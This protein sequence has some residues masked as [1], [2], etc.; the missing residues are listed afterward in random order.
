MLRGDLHAFVR[1]SFGTVSPGDVFLP[2]WHLEAI[3]HELAK[4]VRGETK[5][6]IIT[7]PPRYLKSIC[8]S[9]ALRLGCLVMTQPQDCMRELCK[10]ACGQ[11]CPGLSRG[12]GGAMVSASFPATQIDPSKNT[13]TEIMTTKRGFRLSTSVGGTLTGRGGNLIIIDD[14]L[15]PTDAQSEKAR[16]RHIEWC[17]NTLFSRL[18]NKENDAI[19]LIM[20][21]LHV[22]DLAGH[23]LE[24]GGWR[25]LNLPAIA[26]I[27]EQV[28]IGP[29]RLHD[30]ARG[31]LLHGERESQTV[32]DTMKVSMGSATFAA[33]YQ[34][35]PVP[36]G[37]NMIDWNWF[38]WHEGC[39]PAPFE[40][41]V[42]SWDTAMK[43]TQLADYSVATVWGDWGDLFF[44]LDLVRE[45][46]DYPALR[47]K[48]I[49]LYE[50][51]SIASGV[52][53]TI[54]I[55]DAGSGTSLK[56]DLGSVGIPA[57][58]VKPRGDKV[59]RMSAVSAK[60]EA[61]AVWLPRRAPWLDDLRT[62]ILAFPTGFMMIRWI[63]SRKRCPGC[64]NPSR[65]GAW[66]EPSLTQAETVSI[67]FSQ[68]G[69]LGHV[70]LEC[71]FFRRTPAPP[72]FSSISTIPAAS[73]ANRM[74][75]S[76]GAFIEVSSSL[77]SA[78]RMVA[79][80][81]LEARARS[82][83]LQR[84]NARAARICPPVRGRS[85]ILRPPLI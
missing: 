51:W 32:L 1:K 64:H 4:V 62:E 26:E 52:R 5:R 42:I 11:A 70:F 13:E 63:R 31:E 72:P 20:Q 24:G 59:M 68:P 15:K 84:K 60:I 25:Q 57:I 30:R 3:C 49:E 14:P 40:R 37:G 56:Q 85:F 45:R 67:V 50:H 61:G 17:S 78:R 23:L 76:L 12:N 6:L 33:Q 55:E 28:E 10:G 69:A 66:W 65:P 21:R 53:P 2:N 19:I 36:P 73:R 38:K 71:R 8:A 39:A 81:T 44:L 41:I 75:L 7:I 34:Q 79:T 80:P 29:G 54:L 9:V 48:L 22:G 47:H 74:A 77:S 58:A 43:P 46:L 16:A 18:D 82:S 35:S 83:A 27:D